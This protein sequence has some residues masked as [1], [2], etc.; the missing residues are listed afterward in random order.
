MITTDEVLQERNRSAPP[1][2]V[3]CQRHLTSRD[4]LV[5]IWQYERFGSVY[6]YYAL[7]AQKSLMGYN[8]G[9]AS[10]LSDAINTGKQLKDFNFEQQGDIIE[11][12]YRIKNGYSP[13]WGLGDQSKLAVYEHF[14]NQL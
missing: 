3:C 9:G 10:A 2:C 8:Y 1:I 7:M 4:E 6:I 11:D 5:H 13:T 14:A 12:Y